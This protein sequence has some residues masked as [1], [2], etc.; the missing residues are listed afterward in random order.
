MTDYLDPEDVEALLDEE[1]FHYKDGAR[2]RNLL[3]SALAAP[4]PVFGEDVHPTLDEKAAVLLSAVMRNHALADG[5]KR[6]AWIVTVAFLELNG[7]DLVVD[8]VDGTDRFLRTV[9]PGEIEVAAVA[10]WVRERMHPLA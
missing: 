9:A 6:L 4:M 7:G 1:G 2:G 8:D 3:L 10:E 5:N